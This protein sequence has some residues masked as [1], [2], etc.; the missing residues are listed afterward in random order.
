METGIY[1]PIISDYGFKATFGNEADSLFLRTA[2][3]ALIKLETPI[4]AVHFDKNAF[5]ALTVDSRSGIFD[6]SRTDEQGNHFIVEMPVGTGSA[7]CTADEI[8]CPAQV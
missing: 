2:L 8:L 6:V 4:R 3:Q 7:L 5:D 1:I